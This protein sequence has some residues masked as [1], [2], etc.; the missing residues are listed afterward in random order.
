MPTPTEQLAQLGIVL[1]APPKPV[2]AYIPFVR[3]GD[4]VFISGQIPLKDGAL[5]AQGIVG[6]DVPPEVAK[7]CARQ[8]AINALAVVASAVGSL[9]NVKRVVRLGVF[10]ASPPGFHGQ[11][12]IANGASELMVEVFGD[13][14]RHARAAVG[15]SDLP[16]GAPVEVDAIF[17]VAP[18]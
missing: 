14:G 17:E 13:A 3:T 6:K 15:S 8:C 5:V 16:L 4:L 7:A 2:A 1:P 18:A 9:D 12:G 10:V 11:P